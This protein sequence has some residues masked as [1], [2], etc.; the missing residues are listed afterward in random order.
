M[1]YRREID[2]LR[3]LAVLPVV[4]YHADFAWFSG[5][6]VGVDVFFVIS[7]YLISLIILSE[8][9]AGQFSLIGFYE[10]RAR[11]ILPALFALMMVVTPFAW[12]VMM[13]HQFKDYAQSLVATSLF[14]ANVLFWLESGYFE[15]ASELKPLLHTW[16][17]AVEEQFYFIYPLVVLLV[18]K[19]W[20]SALPAV[21]CIVLVLSF[22]AAHHLVSASPNANFYLPFSRA[23][24]LALG[25]MAAYFVL[26]R[27]LPNYRCNSLLAIG[28]VLMIVAS[29]SFLD[30]DTPFPGAYAIPAV[31]GSGLIILF[32]QPSNFVG[33]TL[34]FGPIVAIG[35]VS[36]SFY[37]WHFP[38]FAITRLWL[39]AEPSTPMYA[40]LIVL[41]YALAVLSYRFIETPF[42]NREGIPRR[43]VYSAAIVGTFFF[44]AIGFHGHVK[45]GYIDYKLAQLPEDRVHL[46]VDIQAER[47][48]RQAVWAPLLDV[49]TRPFSAN[50]NRKVL[51]V[52][53]SVAEDLYIA[54]AVD[55]SLY[56]DHEFRQLRL[57]DSCMRFLNE[58]SFVSE[59]CRSEVAA[60]HETGLAEQAD[61]VLITATWQQH[62]VTSI[63]NVIRF[64][65][66]MGTTVRVFGSANF[67]DIASLSYQIARQG[68]PPQEWG[69]FFAGNKRQDW[70][71]QNERLQHILREEHVSYVEKYDAY[72][73]VQLEG[74]QCWVLTEDGG[75]LIYDTGHVTVE[76]VRHLG[77]KSKDLGWL[78]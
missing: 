14:S 74:E 64:F 26:R 71:S 61:I 54:L 76:G 5:G 25:A 42:R 75:A 13:P 51:V 10:R 7:G 65:S 39:N 15:L 37:L 12:L 17:L 29:I 73:T 4:L 11:R 53:D 20:R 69:R 49:A 55:G 18:V 63:R 8:I 48:A 3:A 78:R 21:L 45:N 24:E 77:R 31:L 59:T 56:E 46:V 70:I 52:G 44:S 68:I 60:F 6:F 2:G 1:K 27:G 50:S 36:Y 38:V 58:T 23:W 57:D 22:A 40:V 19:Y 43:A 30:A 47:R 28:G 72:C 41:S 34:S 62:T 16:S 33:R 9:K 67:N 35:L 66:P 32:A